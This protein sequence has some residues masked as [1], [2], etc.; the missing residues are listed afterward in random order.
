MTIHKQYH[1]YNEIKD[2]MYSRITKINRM[3]TAILCI[4]VVYLIYL[5]VSIFL[6]A[7]RAPL[8]VIISQA[9]VH[10]TVYAD[11]VNE[12]STILFK[13]TGFLVAILYIVLG[14]YI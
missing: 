10:G 2:E 6:P 8:S 7:I 12:W 13:V 4:G 14:T 11:R 1:E 3:S 9:I 5:T